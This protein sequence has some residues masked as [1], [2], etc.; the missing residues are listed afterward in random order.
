MFKLGL[1]INPIAGMGG[2]VGLKGTDGK[3]T[4]DIAIQKGAIPSSPVR[5]AQALSKLTKVSNQFK[6]ITCPGVMGEDIAQE[7]GLHYNI[8]SMVLAGK[9]N[10]EDTRSAADL[11]FEQSVDLLLF[12]GGDGTARDIASVIGEKQLSL[13]IPAGVKIHSSVFALSPLYAAE[14]TESLIRG[15]KP[16]PRLA[17]VMDIDEEAFRADEVRA[18]LFGYLKVPG[19][20]RGIQVL[21]TGSTSLE[22]AKQQAI[23]SFF[24]EEMS[25]DLLYLIGP[26]TTTRELLRKFGH[27]GTLLG[28]DALKDGAIV[29]LD[30]NESQCL[31]LLDKHNPGQVRIVVTPI[32]GQGFIFGRGNQ[33]LSPK[34]IR[35]VIPDGII[36]VSTPDKLQALQGR[37]FRIDTG[38]PKLD[39][40]LA[41]VYQVLTGYRESAY[42]RIEIK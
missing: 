30:L 42:Y 32:G 10:S 37:P 25:P 27:E 14:I 17:E 8:I 33:Q 20:D 26:G 18:R 15:R 41:G 35:H 28:I 21:K 19:V 23:A 24:A 9:T 13:G 39:F 38:D 3:E 5:A 29:A 12:V 34:V 4:L 16:R 36:I 22:I 2:S 11:L 1:I 7:C 31:E 40:K 6:L